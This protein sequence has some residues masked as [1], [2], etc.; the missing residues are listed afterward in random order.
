MEESKSKEKADQP[1]SPKKVEPTV[2][3]EKSK[4]AKHEDEEEEEEVA[5]EAG[6]SG[7]GWGSWTSGWIDTG[8]A[9]ALLG[10]ALSSVN[11]AVEVAKTKSTEAYGFVS[12]D[13]E[14][15][16]SQAINVFGS[17][18][19]NIKQTLEV[20]DEK[21]DVLTDKAVDS[22]KKSVS[23]FWRYASGYAQQMFDEE[24]LESE[25]LLVQSEDGGAPIVL[26][27]L[28]AQL[29]ALAS[30][31][32]TFLQDP[33]PLDDLA[34][35]W[36]SWSCDLEKRQGEISDLMVNS[37]HMRKNYSSLV[38]DKVSHKVFWN[39]YFYKVHL[40]ELQERKRQLLKARAEYHASDKNDVLNAWDDEDERK[41]IPDEVQDRLLTDYERELIAKKLEKSRI[42]SEE[43]KKSDP[44][45]SKYAM[46]EKGDDMIYITGEDVS[47]VEK[48]E[49]S[50]DDWEKLSSGEKSPRK[51]SSSK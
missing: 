39:R 18:A 9:S 35:D 50:S 48:D 2:E 32:D 28:Q 36:N 49:L 30:D 15:V 37:I 4:E 25:A 6:S 51:S 27:R 13:L 47:P 14:E 21:T 22:V 23:S 8:S 16:S 19:T 10:K 41:E 45:T 12:K 29:L 1:E 34:N 43:T 46:K 3:V 20:I 31:P 40:I 33:D 7:G 44:V 42:S 17:T 26:D 38:P 11:A 5:E 24:D